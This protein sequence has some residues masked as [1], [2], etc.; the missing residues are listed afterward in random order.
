MHTFGECPKI[1][2]I[3][4][5]MH[6]VGNWLLRWLKTRKHVV[7]LSFLCVSLSFNMGFTQWFQLLDSI[8]IKLGFVLCCMAK[9]CLEHPIGQTAI[10][11]KRLNAY[12]DD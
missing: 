12:V 3:A 2:I 11:I 10:V 5:P 7:R 9:S 4:C 6:A 1:V 8:H